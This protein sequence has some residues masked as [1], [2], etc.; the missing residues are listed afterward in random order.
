VLMH[1]SAPTPYFSPCLDFWFSPSVDDEVLCD[2]YLV[3]IKQAMLDSIEKVIASG[4]VYYVEFPH[5][6]KVAIVVGK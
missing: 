2:D 1:D 5:M 4:L 3:E 6:A